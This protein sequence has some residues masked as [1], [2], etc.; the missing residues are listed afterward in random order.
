MFR[1]TVNVIVAWTINGVISTDP[2]FQSYISNYSILYEGAGT[3]DST[4]TVPGDTALNG[5]VVECRAL[6]FINSELYNEAESSTLYIQG[7]V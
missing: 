7:M 3:L 4:L 2:M 6:G 5:T 1:C